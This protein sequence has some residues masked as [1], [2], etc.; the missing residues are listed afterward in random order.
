MQ[1]KDLITKQTKLME[2]WNVLPNELIREGLKHA[3]HQAE[4]AENQMTAT[5]LAESYYI[6]AKYC[7]KWKSVIPGNFLSNNLNSFDFY[8]WCFE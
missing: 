4:I 2:L 8:D 1:P 6:L 3:R 5:D 7:H